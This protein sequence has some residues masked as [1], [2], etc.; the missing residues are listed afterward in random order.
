MPLN[1]ET[2]TKQ[3]DI[4][5]DSGWVDVRGDSSVQIIETFN[6]EEDVTIYIFGIKYIYTQG[7]FWRLYIPNHYSS[8]TTT[9]GSWE[10]LSNQ[11]AGKISTSAFD[12]GDLHVLSSDNNPVISQADEANNISGFVLTKGRTANFRSE[13]GANTGH[14]ITYRAIAKRNTTED[15]LARVK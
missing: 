3:S 13:T 4:L 10:N 8:A 15:L 5:Y 9:L 6:F 11:G 7:S 14:G 1:L 12:E 2:Q